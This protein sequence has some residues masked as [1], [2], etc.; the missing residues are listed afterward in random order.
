MS[1]PL[2]ADAEKLAALRQAD[3]ALGILWD[4]K[5]DPET[6]DPLVIESAIRAVQKA[7]RGESGP[8]SPVRPPTSFDTAIRDVENCLR[9][10]VPRDSDKENFEQLRQAVAR[11]Q[12]SVPVRDPAP[13]LGEENLDVL[14]TA[15]GALT[16]DD[17][18]HLTETWTD[19]DGC[20]YGGIPEWRASLI[21]HLRERW[22][23]HAVPVP[24]EHASDCLR[25][26]PNEGMC[27][28]WPE[29][30]RR[31]T[32]WVRGVRDPSP[33]EAGLNL[34]AVNLARCTSP[35]G[36]NHPLASWSAAEWT[37]AVA[38]EAG[39]ACNL[40]KKLIRH[41]DGVPGNKKAEDQDKDSLRRRIA[42]ELADVV[43][44]C[45]LAMASVGYDFATTV[46]DVFNRKS[47]ELG[48]PYLLSGV[49]G[50]GVVPP[51][52]MSG[53]ASEIGQ[54]CNCRSTDGD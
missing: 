48:S 42:E 36:F 33:P 20:F 18:I 26:A 38:G 8:A 29:R 19:R 51:A 16:N 52:H 15:V 25:N 41:R 5:R 21:G 24:L 31:L 27:S 50:A 43:I 28:C 6:I 39:E 10:V 37:N 1:K 45:D 47:H 3:Q 34:S 32:A 46:R 2:P 35:D 49:R 30:D 17:V 22:P 11:L 12:A 23:N 40:A 54:P 9:Y 7:L 53:C 44:Y 13:P 14:A 4:A